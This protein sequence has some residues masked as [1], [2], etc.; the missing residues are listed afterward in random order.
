[1]TVVK[2]GATPYYVDCDSLLFAASPAQFNSM[3]LPIGLSTGKLKEQYPG[4]TYNSF[5]GLGPKRFNLVM[6]KDGIR[7]QRCTFAGLN[8]TQICNNGRIDSSMMAK[9]IQEGDEIIVP[10]YVSR[11]TRTSRGFRIRSKYKISAKTTS[12]SRYCPPGLRRTK[13][14]KNVPVGSTV[15]IIKHTEI[16]SK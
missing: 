14:M 8:P 11:R 3:K 4:A 7:S 15:K 13:S 2:A 12:K 10:H 1:M 16:N 6:T 5:Q 9:I